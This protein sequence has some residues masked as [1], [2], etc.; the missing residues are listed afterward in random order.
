MHPYTKLFLYI[1]EKV[2]VPP[3]Q[4]FPILY[5]FP[6]IG[7]ILRTPHKIPPIY[8][9]KDCVYP[10]TRWYSGFPIYIGRILRTPTQKL[11]HIYGN[12]F[13]NSVKLYPSIIPILFGWFLRVSSLHALVFIWKTFFVTLATVCT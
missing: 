5:L 6:Y 1:W 8:L 7:K 12:W 10:H 11:S 2:C 3:R 13:L 4:A 9:G